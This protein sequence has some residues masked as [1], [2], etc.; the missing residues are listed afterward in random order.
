MKETR[1][2]RLWG[3]LDMSVARQDSAALA[4]FFRCHTWLSAGLGDWKTWLATRSE[5][6]RYQQYQAS[7]WATVSAPVVGRHDSTRTIE[8]MTPL[9]HDRQNHQYSHD[10]V[11][12]ALSPC[13]LQS[14]HT[15]ACWQ[16]SS[17]VWS[18]YTRC[19]LSV[20]QGTVN[21]GSTA[22]C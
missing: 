3:W 2:E 13:C 8:A 10:A 15:Y 21:A 17:A 9:K 16:H 14:G 12:L 6:N 20:C 4:L 1:S 19:R 22:Q 11:A 7:G 18:L 5:C